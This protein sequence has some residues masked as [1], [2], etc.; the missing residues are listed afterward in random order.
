MKKTRLDVEING[1]GGF[2]QLEAASPAGTRFMRKVQGFAHGVAYCDDT[3]M[4]QDIA[5]G[6]CL[7]GLAVEVNGVAYKGAK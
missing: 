6:A 3:R 4:T 7:A 5:D 1:S 2:Y